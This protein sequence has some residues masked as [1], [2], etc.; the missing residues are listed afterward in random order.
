MACCHGAWESLAKPSLSDG[1]RPGVHR[2]IWLETLY[3]HALRTS[4]S[5][6]YGPTSAQ[7]D[8]GGRPTKLN[9]ESASYEPSSTLKLYPFFGNV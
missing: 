3:V 1:R 9:A 2:P 4:E 7:L 8:D 5:S 6:M